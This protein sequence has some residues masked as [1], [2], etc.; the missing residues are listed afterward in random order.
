L[1]DYRKPRD[2]ISALLSSGDLVRVKKGLYVFAAPHRKRLFSRE[3]LAN[4][5]YGPSYVSLDYALAYHGMVPERVEVVTSVTT[6]KKR[7][8]ETPVGR[9]SY[10]PLSPRRYNRGI[11]RVELPGGGAFL[12]ATREKALLDKAW[13]DKRFHPSG[14]ADCL[15]YLTED[16]RIDES[17][18]LALDLQALRDIGSRFG[19]R[20]VSR[21][22]GCVEK[23]RRAEG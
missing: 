15:A 10:A 5:I 2:K 13:T 3:L 18:L 7:Q 17:H 23:M 19:S 8:Y 21:I 22:V 9:F 12:V 20:K 14:F 1:K 16:L 6:G 4:L 11:D